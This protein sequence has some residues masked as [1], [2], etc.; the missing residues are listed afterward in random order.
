MLAPPY[1]DD[2][3]KPALWV[4]ACYAACNV[5][6]SPRAWRACMAIMARDLDMQRGLEATWAMGN[7]EKAAKAA[8]AYFDHFCMR[9]ASAKVVPCLLRLQE[10][11][12]RRIAGRLGFNGRPIARPSDKTLENEALTPWLSPRVRRKRG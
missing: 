7:G 10:L 3:G 1:V 2:A 4:H 6:D 11:R 8:R 12:R 9:L 5:T